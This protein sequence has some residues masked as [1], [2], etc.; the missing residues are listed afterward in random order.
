MKRS[1]LLE[2]LRNE[3]EMPM[4][5]IL[6]ELENTL[7]GLAHVPHFDLDNDGAIGAAIHGALPGAL[8][9]VQ[10]NLPGEFLA[11]RYVAGPANKVAGFVN[12]NG[13]DRSFCAEL[14]L[15]GA[16]G[17]T[18]KCKHQ[19]ASLDQ[20]MTGWL[21]EEM[22]MVGDTGDLM[23]L[24]I[25]YRL[26]ASRTRIEQAW[27]VLADG[28]TKEKIELRQIESDTE[29]IDDAQPEAPQESGKVIALKVKSRNLDAGRNDGHKDQRE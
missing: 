6:R 25:A 18:G 14:H 16:R 20:D 21:F 17:G 27:L 9:T 13:S 22:E 15:A 5:R 8:A 11:K 12:A 23:L 19:F 24:F 7:L 28:G 1:E 3:L 4:W 26:S 10:E 29:E 2:T